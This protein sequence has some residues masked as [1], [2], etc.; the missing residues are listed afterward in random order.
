ML[1]S[2][3]DHDYMWHIPK[4]NPGAKSK[5]KHI[6]P[7]S[8][9]AK[10]I[11]IQVPNCYESDHFFRGKGNS[12]PI[13]RKMNEIMLRLKRQELAARGDI[14]AQHVTIE[15]W[16]FHDLRRT[17]ATIMARLGHDK[18]VVHKILNH[19][20]GRD[21]GLGMLDVVYIIYDYM[22]ER[23]KALQDLGN[24]ISRVVTETPKG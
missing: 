7:L 18:D 6:V 23:V 3:V 10:E 14:N 2:E 13:K 5:H 16:V 15:P 20:E 11:I 19:S 12:D 21:R 4:T 1:R 8:N 24:Y 22:P 17:A 9:L